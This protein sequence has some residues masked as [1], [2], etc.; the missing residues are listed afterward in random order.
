[1]DSSKSIATSR[2]LSYL[3]L[4]LGI[5]TFFLGWA[6]SVKDPSFRTHSYL[7]KI[8]IVSDILKRGGWTSGYKL[9]PYALA[10]T[11]NDEY[12]VLQFVIAGT[13]S[14]CAKTPSEES[15]LL[16]Q[17]SG[18]SVGYYYLQPYMPPLSHFDVNTNVQKSARCKD[19]LE[20]LLREHPLLTSADPIPRARL[21]RHIDFPGENV[22]GCS[23]IVFQGTDDQSYNMPVLYIL[24]KRREIHGSAVYTVFFNDRCLGQNKL[25][26]PVPFI[27]IDDT[28]TTGS[29]YAT[30]PDWDERTIHECATT[31]KPADWIDDPRFDM[32]SV[33]TKLQHEFLDK[34]IRRIPDVVYIENVEFLRITIVR[35]AA[36]HGGTLYTKA[37]WKKAANKLFSMAQEKPNFLGLTLDAK[38]AIDMAPL[39]MFWFTVLLWHSVRRID[40]SQR[41][42]EEPWILIDTKGKIEGVLAAFWAIMLLASVVAVFLAVLVFNDASFPRPGVLLFFWKVWRDF[43]LGGELQSI[44]Q[45]MILWKAVIGTLVLI[46]AFVPLIVVIHI[47]LK[48]QSK[49]YDGLIARMRLGRKRWAIR[50]GNGDMV[51][52]NQRRMSQ[53]FFNNYFALLLREGNRVLAMLLMKVKRLAR[54]YRREWKVEDEGVGQEPG[55]PKEGDALDA[56]TR[57]RRQAP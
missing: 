18:L 1:M 32:R 22:F 47:I 23:F 49:L 27:L 45:G 56:A 38:W 54:H 17:P 20:F 14:V 4:A 44:I 34:A 16:N 37:N 43:H 42:F 21:F 25:D 57:E 10:G 41:P 52:A 30:I 8:I 6:K 13:N 19:L 36:L 28:Q 35:D 40:F 53:I 11:F 31:N 9:T 15:A 7:A 48:G 5:I 39:V 26:P 33:L 3:I 12:D 55:P 2:R 50:A 51:A 46:I 24:G 29:W